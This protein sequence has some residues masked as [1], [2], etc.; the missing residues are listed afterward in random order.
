MKFVILALG[1]LTVGSQ[2]AFASTSSK[3][4]STGTY[5]CAS[6]IRTARPGVNYTL[7]YGEEF[8]TLQEAKND[9]LVRCRE[10][11]KGRTWGALCQTT[12]GQH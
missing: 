12:C 1:F 10:S 3:D 6:Y 9:A 7:P 8:A 5:Q 11:D 2:V 4:A